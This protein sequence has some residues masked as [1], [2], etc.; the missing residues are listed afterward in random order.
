[1]NENL[2]MKAS[3]L[4]IATR[5]I[6]IIII[7]LILVCAFFG[8]VDIRS[9][10]QKE[11]D[12]R[13]EVLEET[14]AQAAIEAIKISQEN[15]PY[16]EIEKV[17]VIGGA[18]KVLVKVTALN[19]VNQYVWTYY[20]AKNNT[21]VDESVYDNLYYSLMTSSFYAGHDGDDIETIFEGKGLII[22]C[23]EATK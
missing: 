11:A 19:G 3:S 15:Y 13:K 1:M 17:S 4:L 7:A 5:I 20:N 22:L 10:E 23:E 9:D 16:A 8:V 12:Y 6:F 18:G 2:K 14:F 21:I